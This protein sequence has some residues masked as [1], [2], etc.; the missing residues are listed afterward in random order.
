MTNLLPTEIN[1]VNRAKRSDRAEQAEKDAGSA[2]HLQRFKDANSASDQAAHDREAN[3]GLGAGA[4]RGSNTAIFCS[5]FC[6]HKFLRGRRE[7]LFE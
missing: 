4:A 1:E 2:L 6:V 7:P 5:C 3:N